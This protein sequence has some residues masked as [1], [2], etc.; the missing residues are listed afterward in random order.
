MKNVPMCTEC[1]VCSEL[2][3]CE[4]IITVIVDIY[5]CTCICMYEYV[6]SETYSCIG[7]DGKGEESNS[8]TFFIYLVT[9]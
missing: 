2:R 4:H 6:I 7:D 3:H 8:D 9:M 5:V 1:P